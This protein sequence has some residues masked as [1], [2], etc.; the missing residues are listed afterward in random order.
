MRAVSVDVRIRRGRRWS[1]RSGSRRHGAQIG[2]PSRGWC[3]RCALAALGRV[4]LHRRERLRRLRGLR[5]RALPQP[6]ARGSS[7]VRGACSRISCEGLPEHALL[8]LRHWLCLRLRLRAVLAR[9]GLGAP[10]AA[11]APWLVVFAEQ[12]DE[13]AREQSDHTPV[14]LQP[15]H[16]PR[17]IAGVEHLDQVALDE[18]EIALSLEGKMAVRDRAGKQSVFPRNSPLLPTSTRPCTS[19]GTAWAATVRPSFAVFLLLSPAGCCPR[20]GTDRAS[21]GE[22]RRH[23]SVYLASASRIRG[24]WGALRTS[25]ERQHSERRL[26]R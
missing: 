4:S 1:L 20:C 17:A 26:R 23:A 12:L 2:G 25:K 14:A 3:W 10:V 8:L 7:W 6:L 5:R 13:V 15:S 18:S 11:A 16:P 22:R 24:G 9:D 21:P 19:T